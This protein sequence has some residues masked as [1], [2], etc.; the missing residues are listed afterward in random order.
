MKMK[1]KGLEKPSLLRLPTELSVP[2]QDLGGYSILLYGEPKVGKTSLC[3]EFPDNVFLMFEPGARAL[4]VHQVELA[5]GAEGWKQFKKYLDL[6]E[7]D[8][9]FR[10]VTMDTVDIAAKACLHYVCE[11]EGFEHPSDEGYG[12]GWDKVN[13]EF[14]LQI[15]R[16]LK[17]DKG[18]IFTSHAAEK[19]IKTRLGEEYT[20]IVP[21]MSN[22]ARA[23]CEALV[24]IWIFMRHEKS[25]ERSMQIRGDGHVSAGHRLQGNFFAGLDKIPAGKTA[26]EAYNNLVA[27]FHNKFTETKHKPKLR[28]KA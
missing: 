2:V 15:R 23:V 28:I 17:L 19:D 7:K 16:I 20:K 21:T 27:A 3:A 12:K 22:S 25:G 1:Q 14:N 5:E 6:L 26:K 4:A 9:R 13:T 24:D 18:V 11:E 10:T 8:K